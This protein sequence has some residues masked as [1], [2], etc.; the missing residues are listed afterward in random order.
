MAP[1]DDDRQNDE[2]ENETIS[3]RLERARQRR[4][5]EDVHGDTTEILKNLPHGDQ[6]IPEPDDASQMENSAEEKQ[7]VT[8]EILEDVTETQ[9]ETSQDLTA[10]TDEPPTSLAKTEAEETK[11]LPSSV[12]VI[13]GM[14]QDIDNLV[15]QIN[16]GEF[17]VTGVGELGLMYQ[18]IKEESYENLSVVWGEIISLCATLWEKGK[19]DEATYLFQTAQRDF[20]VPDDM[21]EQVEKA[22][23]MSQNYQATQEAEKAFA[24]G[25]NQEAM[26]IAESITGSEEG[27][28]YAKDLSTRIK[29]RTKS[30]KIAYAVSLV[31]VMGLITMS[32]ISIQTLEKVFQA[33]PTPSYQDFTGNLESVSED[34]RD[35]RASRTTTLHQT[36]R[37]D[38]ELNSNDDTA[39][40]DV[41]T[42]LTQPDTQELTQQE[43]EAKHNCHLGYAVYLQGEQM[44][45]ENTQAPI[46][47]KLL[48]Q[49]N[50][51]SFAEQLNQSCQKFNMSVDEIQQAIETMNP[52][53]VADI[54]ARIISTPTQ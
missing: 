53:D 23:Q 22:S 48:Q 44:I 31:A 52:K 38:T 16:N 4:E 3:E 30:R 20:D 12:G 18:S 1:I 47:D 49:K 50:L 10:K 42:V 51:A 37:P 24:L 11:P 33:P 40:E 36:P 35:V 34:L 14:R 5:E 25:A 7:P 27:E 13:R 29:K 19:M 26:A 2:N 8:E 54:A 43:I 46:N 21:K 28:E 9:D 39:T 15:I 41:T 6:N 17:S 45:N 32:Y